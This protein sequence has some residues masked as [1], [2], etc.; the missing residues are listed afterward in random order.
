MRPLSQRWFGSVVL[1]VVVSIGSSFLASCGSAVKNVSIAKDAVTQFHSQLDAEQ[2]SAV[3]A[4]T[5][6]GFRSASTEADFT[7]LLEAI[8]RKLGT[9]RESDLQNV[10]VAWHTGE[11]ATVNLTYNTKFSS[12]SGIE[13]FRWHISDNR[14]QLFAYRINSN[15]L[16]TK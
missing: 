15:D 2:Y 3:Y 12:G 10:N 7:K 9:V 5:D 6:T 16:I 14:A 11:G 8:H 13:L 4:A 1:A